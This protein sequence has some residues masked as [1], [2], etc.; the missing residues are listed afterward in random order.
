MR[1]LKF[2]YNFGKKYHTV[3]VKGL[4]LCSKWKIPTLKHF[5]LKGSNNRNEQLDFTRNSAIK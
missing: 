1:N 5:I 4:L 3:S 2:Y